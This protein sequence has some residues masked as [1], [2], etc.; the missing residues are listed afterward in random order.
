[1]AFEHAVPMTHTADAVDPA[2][3]GQVAPGKKTRTSGIP[4]V[5]QG[6][7]CER[8]DDPAAS[9]PAQCDYTPE[10]R[11]RLL[12]VLAAAIQGAFANWRQALQSAQIDA[13]TRRPPSHWGPGVEFLFYAVTGPLVAYLA[14]SAAR[15]L[16]LSHGGIEHVKAG[17]TNASRSLRKG[18]QGAI[19]GRPAG[20]AAKVAFLQ[21]LADQ[22]T[23]AAN[24]LIQVIAAGLTDVELRGLVAFYGDMTIHGIGPY[25]ERVNA[26]LTVYDAEHLD[27]VGE[28][29]QFAHGE[30]VWVTMAGKTRMAMLHSYAL[31]FQGV[32]NGTPTSGDLVFEKNPDG[33]I[34]WVDPAATAYAAEIF[35]AKTGRQPRALDAA[36]VLQ[37]EPKAGGE[38]Y[39]SALT[40]E[41][42]EH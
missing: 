31:E 21:M 1:M 30:P 11:T 28:E 19:D 32:A 7:R 34:H 13:I 3:P 16:E 10:Q 36:D 33:S 23:P 41:P 15:G 42:G 39:M 5:D 35:T 6:T 24:L 4:V 40:A 38:A 9:D 2:I 26:Q 29:D 25:R 22:L 18:L 8:P 12:V 37:R 17:L 14:G 20:V 27:T